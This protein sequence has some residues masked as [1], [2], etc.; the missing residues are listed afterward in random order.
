MQRFLYRHDS[1]G[2]VTNKLVKK[3]RQVQYR[4]E[5]AGTESGS[6]FYDALDCCSSNVMGCC[7]AENATG[8]SVDGRVT[9]CCAGWSAVLLK[10]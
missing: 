10:V 6:G 1:N 9:G 3:Q 4:N 2:H 7:I 5:D 8:C